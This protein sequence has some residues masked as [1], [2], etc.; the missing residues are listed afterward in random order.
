MLT[1]EYAEYEALYAGVIVVT[2]QP[3]IVPESR[4]CGT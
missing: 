3:N 2:M 1:T 4:N